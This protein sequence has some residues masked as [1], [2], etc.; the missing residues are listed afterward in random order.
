MVTSVERWVSSCPVVIVR[1]E[2]KS[3]SHDTY[4]FVMSRSLV[5]C[6]LLIG[7]WVLALLI[8]TDNA[9]SRLASISHPYVFPFDMHDVTDVVQYKT[10]FPSCF[11]PRRND[12]VV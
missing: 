7:D 11:A 3:L 5:G 4:S 9:T 8:A 6:R 12:G 10:E 1:H 2:H